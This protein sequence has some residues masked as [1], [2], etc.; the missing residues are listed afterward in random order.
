MGKHAQKPYDHNV[1]QATKVLEL[2][3]IDTCGP[4]PILTSKKKQ[5]FF[6]IL[7][8]HMSYNEAEPIAKKN[9]CTC[10][11]KDTQAL[12]ENQ[13]NEKVKK[14]CCDGAKE[15]TQGELGQHFKGSGIEVQMM[16]PYAHQQNSKAE[17]FIRTLED[18][19]QMLIADSGLPMSFWGDAVMTASY[20]CKRI[21][22]STLP[23]GKTPYEAMHNEIPNLSHLCQWECQCFAT[24]PPELCTKA[25]PRQFKAIFVRYVEGRIGWWVHDLQ[26]KYHFL[27][28]VEFNKNTLG[29][30]SSKWTL[31]VDIAIKA[32]APSELKDDL[33]NEAPL[34]KRTI[35]PTP[36]MA[37]MQKD[38]KTN[39][40]IILSC[41]QTA[42]VFSALTGFFW[43]EEITSEL[44]P[45]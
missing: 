31:K 36:K 43:A 33:D 29:R 25:R 37:A 28:D 20:T 3:H 21:P 35:K 38:P 12:W 9:D 15:F 16:A 13:T 32:D 18:D 23:D 42:D 7:D 39:N 45:L 2:L 4:M 44:T 11:F 41:L 24:I 34:P 14:V 19:A 1:N 6:V 5:Y 10:V 22:T 40:G 26:G 8:D 30:L 17:Q 27:C